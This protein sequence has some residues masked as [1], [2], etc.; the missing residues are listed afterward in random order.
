M[1]ARS[2]HDRSLKQNHLEAWFGSGAS[3][4]LPFDLLHAVHGALGAAGDPFR[5]EARCRG[6]EVEA[7]VACE[8]GEAGQLA[9]FDSVDP[10][11]EQGAEAVG[12]PVTV[13]F[14]WEG[15]EEA[16]R[17]VLVPAATPALWKH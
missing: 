7:P 13:T 10:A 1:T 16:E 4:E 15:R 17:A 3:V 5:G 2:R 11:G 9:G 8:A 12:E 14:L 6:V